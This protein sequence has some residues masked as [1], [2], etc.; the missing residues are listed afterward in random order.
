[1]IGGNGLE[2]GGLKIAQVIENDNI[3]MQLLDLSDNNISEQ[4][5]EKIK[6]VFSKEQTF[7]FMCR[8][9]SSYIIS[10]HNINDIN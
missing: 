6:V 10:S 1:M 4:D 7:N 8:I 3:A 2:C 9:N 5:K